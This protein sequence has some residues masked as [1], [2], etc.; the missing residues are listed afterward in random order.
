MI[1]TKKRKFIFKIEQKW[2]YNEINGIDIFKFVKY[3]QFQKETKPRCFVK[4]VTYTLQSDLTVDEATIMQSYS[5]TVRN[6]IRRSIK[7]K[8]I[9][10]EISPLQFLD[11]YNP[12]ALL[13]KL[14][15]YTP[16]EFD[17]YGSDLFTTGAFIE[18]KLVAAHSYLL[19]KQKG[20][21][22]LLLSC[23]SQLYTEN[24]S[25]SFVARANKGLHYTDM[26]MFKAQGFILYDWGGVS[27][28][29]DPTLEGIRKFKE[30]FGGELVECISYSSYFYSLLFKLASKIKV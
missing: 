27:N 19:D 15:V 14:K 1:N 13:K 21:V 11:F 2:F 5:T 17:E 3:I 22:R 16:K 8:N 18:N 25:K 29:I 7:D 20:I 24:I 4:N 6:E 23:S 9:F 10:T 12:F 30:G 26:L 28:K